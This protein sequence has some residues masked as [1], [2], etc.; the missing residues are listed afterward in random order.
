MSPTALIPG[1]YCATVGEL[2]ALLATL[3]P[4]MPIKGLLDEAISVVYRPEVNTWRPGQSYLQLEGYNADYG[5]L[6][7]CSEVL[8]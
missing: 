1:V 8:S 6:P 5:N 7:H 2:H 3:P 4:E